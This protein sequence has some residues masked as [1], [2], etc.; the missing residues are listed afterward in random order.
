MEENSS[1][2]TPSGLLACCT[3]E[4]ALFL[5]DAQTLEPESA[6]PI[7]LDSLKCLAWAPKGRLLAVGGL[8]R[9]VYVKDF[10]R[11]KNRIPDQIGIGHASS[12]CSLAWSDDAK[13]DHVGRLC[14]LAPGSARDEGRRRTSAAGEGPLQPVL[15]QSGGAGPSESEATNPA[16]AGIQAIRQRGRNDLR[17]RASRE[18]QEGAVQDGQARRVLCDD[19]GTVE[20]GTRS[21]SSI[22]NQLQGGA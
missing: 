11:V 14:G 7:S 12:L 15:E 6:V 1:A 8:D 22:R 20:R 10:R 3:E 16:D 19:D 9:R 4:G 18:G 13:Q 21:L 2:T 17:N 5:C